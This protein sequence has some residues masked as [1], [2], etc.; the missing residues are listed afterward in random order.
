MV[1][2]IRDNGRITKCMVMVSICG[3]ISDYMKETINMIK[4]TDMESILGLT[5]VLFKD[6]GPS[7]SVKERES[8]SIKKD[9]SDR[10]YG[11]RTNDGNGLNNSLTNNTKRQ[12]K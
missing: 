10:E 3:R 4:S 9:R 7:E 8:L 2:N 5:A 11:N 12:M 1:E 6:N